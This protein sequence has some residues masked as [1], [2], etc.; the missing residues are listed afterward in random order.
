MLG[1]ILALIIFFT[2]YHGLKKSKSIDKE[3][4]RLREERRKEIDKTYRENKK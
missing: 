1:S 3:W 2:T 4:E